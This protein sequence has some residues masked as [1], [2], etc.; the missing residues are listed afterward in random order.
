[1][2]VEEMVLGESKNVEFKESL[3]SNAEHY[4][5]TLVAF[6][7]TQGGS[8]L[9]GVE[10]Q[11][12]QVVGVDENTLFQTIDRIANAASDACEPQIV[13]E[14]EP[15]TLDGRTVIVVTVAPGPNRPYYLKA[16]GAEKGTYIRVAG[17]SRPASPEKLRELQ[18]EGAR[19]SWDELTCV[20]YR[21]TDTVISK[22]CRDMNR[23]RK[24]MQEQRRSAEKLPSVTRSNLVNWNILKHTA[25]GFLASNAFALLTGTH[26]RFARTQCAVF[27]GTDR[28]EFIDKQEYSGPLYEQIEAAYAFVLR[29]IRRSARVEG[30]IRRERHELPPNAI[31]EMIVNA[32]CHRSYQDEACVQVALYDDRLEVTSPGGLYGGL[33]LE[34]ALNGRSRQR[35]R[36]IAEAFSQ[37]G[38]IEA[39]G[40]GLKSIRREAKAYGLPD[41]AFIE[42]PETFRVLLFRKASSEP[43]RKNVGPSS[44]EHRNNIGTTSEEVPPHLPADLN[45]TQT[46]ILNLL[47]RQPRLT[48]SA[49][50]GQIGIAQRNIEANIRRLKE[51]GLLVRHGSTKGGYWEVIQASDP[52]VSPA[53]STR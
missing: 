12:R 5:K 27:A 43:D 26:F 13:P 40:N 7:N 15:Y 2:T 22:L 24:S 31:R 48:A 34:E 21:V 25:D 19:I 10:D 46:A 33:T 8:L 36:A 30:L 52:A 18:M 51:L 28:G 44:D 42:M 49:M 23:S 9:L 32:H 47:L 16:K 17:T 4:L 53:P 38:L 35:N 50:A 14:I 45:A 41:P 11:T 6:A 20:G 39:W 1:M 29:N 37:M 3:P